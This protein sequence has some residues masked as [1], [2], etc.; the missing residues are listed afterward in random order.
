MSTA[1]GSGDG[2][3]Y[4][5]RNMRR[6]NSITQPQQ[7]VTVINMVDDDEIRTSGVDDAGRPS[8]GDIRNI[9]GNKRSASFDMDDAQEL[10]KKRAVELGTCNGRAGLTRTGT[11]SL[12]KSLLGKTR[13][14]RRYRSSAKETKA[15]VAVD[16]KDEVMEGTSPSLFPGESG[17]G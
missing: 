6:W 15:A 16:A 8:H 2:Y 7:D 9:T 3:R 1:C 14:G 11:L 17:V 13:R 10:T 4:R 5:H 12:S